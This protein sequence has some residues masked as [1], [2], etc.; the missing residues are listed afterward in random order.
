MG[1]SKLPFKLVVSDLVS[2][3]VID[4]PAHSGKVPSKTMK[5]GQND[6]GL[7][8]V[9]SQNTRQPIWN[10]SS[11]HSNFAL[12]AVCAVLFL[13]FLDMTIVSVALASVQSSLHAGVTQL[14]WVVNGYALTF[15]SLML[16]AGSLSDRFGRKRVMLGG[17]VIFAAGSLLGA[18]APN[19][20]LLITARVIMGVGAAA[21]EPG[22]LS[23]IRHL[24]PDSEERARAL[25]AWAAV[26]GL[27]LAL[28][29]VIGGALVA[30][31]SWRSVFWFN[32]AAV[33]CVVLLAAN[34]VPESVDPETTRLDILGFIAGAVGIGALTFATTLGETDG[35]R[36]PQVIG[37]FIGG[38]VA[39]AAFGHIER[40]SAAPMLNFDYF[41]S[42]RFTG[43]IVIA[44]VL[45]FGIFS[46]FFFTAL[47]LAAVI[48]YSPN[49][50]ALEFLPMAI[51]MIV[52]A[53]LA[54][55][56][57]ARIGPR[58]PMAEGCVLSGAGILLSALLLTTSPPSLWLMATL[59]LAGFG[60]G[61]SVVPMTS[62]VLAEVPPEHSG[63]AASATN[64]SR[65]LG[66]VFGVAVLGALVNAH[67]TG[68][69]TSRL[70]TLHIP[71][72]FIAIVIGAVETGTVPG[73][74][75][76]ASTIEERVIQAAYGAFRS[77]LEEALVTSGI[78][79]L[80][81]GVIGA[82]TLR[83]GSAH[84]MKNGQRPISEHLDGLD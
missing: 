28:G 30:L 51:A 16:L 38:T 59:A 1:P 14:Q 22:T 26:S 68:D 66:A 9:R 49:R 41:R 62:V 44:F 5:R 32:V 8:V 24:Y 21:S 67:L 37:L 12:A 46:I 34:A 58:L 76:G 27:A 43:A 64:T 55:R 35:Y 45:F 50:I 84:W 25:G 48:G 11:S 2:G 19:P 36:A 33:S 7:H 39:L 63:M 56:R 60:F 52:A 71:S 3:N 29:P 69:L 6:H 77:G 61:S 40:S 54:G 82:A 57:V 42:P 18:L 75:Q 47:Y 74:V 79:M 13:T 4:E 72:N 83:T 23:I 53:G 78:A 20:D 70:R 65:E 31:G 15:A 80:I 10:R 17:L 73:G 81:A